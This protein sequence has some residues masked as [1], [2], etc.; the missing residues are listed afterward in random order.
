MHLHAMASMTAS[1]RSR[2][3]IE[4]ARRRCLRA[5]QEDM[6]GVGVSLARVPNVVPRLFHTSV[7]V[8]FLD[9]VFSG[10]VANIEHSV[11]SMPNGIAEDIKT[12]IVERDTKVVFQEDDSETLKS[13]TWGD[14]S[15]RLDKPGHE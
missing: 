2:D 4:A 7:K 10:N 6:I 15:D 9:S 8:L 1:S 5:K 12:A 13:R 11:D 14:D 3:L